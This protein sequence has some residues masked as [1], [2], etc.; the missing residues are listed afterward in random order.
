MT[1]LGKRTIAELFPAACFIVT[2]LTFCEATA[3]ADP[4]A[5]LP[6]LPRLK[7]HR[8]TAL[9]SPEEA[10]IA[11]QLDK[12]VRRDQFV[13]VP[14]EEVLLSLGKWNGVAIEF[15]ESSLHEMRGGL[16]QEVTLEFPRMPWPPLLRILLEPVGMDWFIR[17][18]KLVI[19]RRTK[20]DRHLS[21]WKYD[22]NEL[23]A[24]GI[25]GDALAS[26]IREMVVPGEW[27]NAGGEGSIAID[28][29][30]LVVR[31]GREVHQQV[32]QLLRFVRE[33][34]TEYRRTAATRRSRLYTI[35]YT[36]E[37]LVEPDVFISAISGP[38]ISNVFHQTWE[39][40][41][42]TGRIAIN[43]G[44]LQVTHFAWVHDRLRVLLDMARDVVHINAD[45]TALNFESR[46]RTVVKLLD[47]ID[48]S[49]G[50]ID[51]PLKIDF[52]SLELQDVMYFFSQ[53]CGVACHV[54]DESRARV[55]VDKT[56]ITCTQKQGTLAS[57][58]DLI[59]E[60]LKL[61]WFVVHD[62]LV[63]V[64]PPEVAAKQRGVQVYRIREA[65][66]SGTAVADIIRKMTSQIEPQSWKSAGGTADVRTLPGLLVISHHRRAHIQI[67]RLLAELGQP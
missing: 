64:V 10:K 41:Y 67:A 47:R 42:G 15:D 29:E 30:F 53:E 25:S 39:T 20:V 48:L 6:V 8:E 55:P 62:G 36:L 44:N 17:N 24:A 63:R 5:V 46:F 40:T 66:E 19:S 23:V 4:P 27:Q 33:E 57:A 58:L 43:D 28:G 37:N 35:Q 1:R 13:Q 26:T 12:P 51:Q 7:V 49:A 38:I 9:A 54:T 52:Q 22:V 59:L 65:V 14:L 50:D 11:R 56:L 3:F 18:D 61:D 31:Q 32:S 34:L 2:A 45:G 21:R 16:K 60:P